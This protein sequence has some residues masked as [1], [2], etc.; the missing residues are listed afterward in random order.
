MS[1]R[2]LASV[3]AIQYIHRALIKQQLKTEA[4]M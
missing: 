3:L 1:D 4:Q 2:E